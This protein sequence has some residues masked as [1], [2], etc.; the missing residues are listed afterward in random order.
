MA[1]APLGT[2]PKSC[3]LV[4]ILSKLT[5]F[6][7]YLSKESTMMIWCYHLPA[8]EATR[9]CS[10]PVLVLTM[11]WGILMD[12]L[13]NW[14]WVDPSTKS[15]RAEV[16]DHCGN[17]EQNVS[18]NHQ[19]WRL[20]VA[21]YWLLIAAKKGDY[22]ACAIAS[23]HQLLYNSWCARCSGRVFKCFHAVRSEHFLD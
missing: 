17:Q 6:L 12:A 4:Y 21:P 20:A 8:F 2:A 7:I 11:V 5:L 15:F 13:C 10:S 18:W 22:C 19:Q 14:L 9:A 16:A 23:S 3:S 1:C